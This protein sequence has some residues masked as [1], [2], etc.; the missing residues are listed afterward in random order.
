M[1]IGGRDDLLVVLELLE[2]EFEE[3]VEE[4]VFEEEEVVTGGLVLLLEVVEVMGGLVL[5]LEDVDDVV[6]GAVVVG[7]GV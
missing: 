7:G 4:L 2:L 5:V 6:G 1:E 3:L